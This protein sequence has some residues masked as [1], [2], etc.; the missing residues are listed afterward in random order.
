MIDSRLNLKQREA[1]VAITT[2]VT[3]PLP[4]ILIIG[5]FG[6]GKTYTLAQAIK[7]LIT[8]PESRVLVCTHSNSAAD[9]Y[10]KDYLHPYVE[11]GHEEARPLRIYYH[12]RWVATVNSVVQKV[13]KS[14]FSI[15]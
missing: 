5:P 13:C 6:T 4:P 7:Q 8:Q 9:L 15:R 12:K 14:K 11:A 3:T 2:P 10:I 1:V